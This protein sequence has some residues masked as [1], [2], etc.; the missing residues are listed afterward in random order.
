M[1]TFHTIL[2]IRFFSGKM[3]ELF[4]E[5]QNGGLLVVPSGPNLAGELVHDPAYRRAVQES[6]IAITDSGFMVLIWRMLTRE[7]IE[8]ISGLKLVRALLQRDDFANKKKVLWVMPTEPDRDALLA[9]AAER[10]MGEAWSTT[11][12]PFY[13][14]SGDLEDPALVAEIEAQQPD[15]VILCIAGG[16]QERLGW[17]LRK[18]LSIRPLIVCIGAAIAF[19]TGRQASIPDWA[20]RLM[21]GWLLRC[22]QMPSKFVPRYWKA[23]KLLRI[24][25]RH[26]HQ[27]PA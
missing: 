10:S 23:Q 4:Q 22:F 26:R 16:T 14:R 27:S 15:Y 9:M 11:I 8:R 24:M 2:G 6:D 20:D 12:A 13:P 25:L 17:Y 5:A 7:S 21:L 1:P 3:D 19:E 18:N